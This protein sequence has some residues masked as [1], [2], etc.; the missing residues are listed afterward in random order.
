MEQNFQTSFIPKKPIIKENTAYGGRSIGVFF[1]ISLFIFF[2]V[3]IVTGGLYFYKGILVK[4]IANMENTLNLAKNRFEPA[5]ITELQTFDKRL[6][7][8]SE[9]LAKHI[10]VVPIFN[11]LEQLTMKSVR[12]TNFSY[13]M[14]SG[15]KNT[16][17][18][19]MS[20]VAI[21]YRSIALQY[22]L[23]AKNKNLIDPIF[24]NLTLDN[25][26]NVLFDLQFSVDPSFVNYKQ[27][28]MVK[29]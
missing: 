10:T 2:A 23:F 19:K 16:I 1:I 24:S 4:K 11:A 18:V 14:E 21:G 20:G 13:N 15:D 9:I 3:L 27:T 26:G 29:S 12:Y 17:N 25:S 6:I 5:K 28:L 7:Y 8:S 22:D